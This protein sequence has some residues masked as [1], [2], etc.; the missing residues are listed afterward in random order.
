[1]SSLIY[2]AFPLPLI[3]FPLSDQSF[4][5]MLTH[6][7]IFFQ[8]LDLATIQLPCVCQFLLQ[9]RSFIHSHC[10]YHVVID[11]ICTSLILTATSQAS[12]FS[13]CKH[14]PVFQVLPLFIILWYCHLLRPLGTWVMVF[15][16]ISNP[17]SL[18]NDFKEYMA[19][20]LGPLFS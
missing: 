10:I 14:F 8:H 1:M 6:P 12:L 13:A 19:S 7:K 15:L 18:H 3:T 9:R 16:F 11:G 17:N 20:L 5:C 4:N 2:S